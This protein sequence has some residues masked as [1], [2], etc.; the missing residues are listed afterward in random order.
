MGPILDLRLKK[1]MSFHGLIPATGW[2]GRTG[3]VLRRHGKMGP[4]TLKGPFEKKTL[5][6][7]GPH[8]PLTAALRG[9][10]KDQQ[11]HPAEPQSTT[12]S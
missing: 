4:V 5:N 3:E 7:P 6:V 12:D 10:K 2:Q 11:N 1:I 9:P 8:L